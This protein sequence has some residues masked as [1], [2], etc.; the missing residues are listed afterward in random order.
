MSDSKKQLHCIEAI[1]GYLPTD[2]VLRGGGYEAEGFMAF[3][4]VPP[5]SAADHA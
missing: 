2:A 4:E 1:Y 5:A 3:Q